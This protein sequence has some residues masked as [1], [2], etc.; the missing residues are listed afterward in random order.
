[1]KN[2]ILLSFDVEHWYLGFK[3][4]GV[5]GWEKDS[6]RDYN[7][8]EIILT[9]LE[10]YNSLAT[11]FVTGKYAE[12]Y[13][14]IVKKIYDKGHEISCHGYSHDYIYKQKPDIFKIETIQA[15]QILEDITGSGVTGYRAASWSITA[16]SLWAL[17]IIKDSGFLYDSSIYPTKNSKYG[18]YRAI[19]EPYKIIFDGGEEL[20]EIPP[21]VLKIGQIK[22]PVCGGIYLRLFPF[23]LNKLSIDIE[24]K[25][26]WPGRVMLHPHEL[27]E[28]PPRLKIN[29]EGWLVKYFRINTVGDTLDK[30]LLNFE[31]VLFEDYYNSLDSKSVESLK[32]D[33]LFK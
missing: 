15:K 4:R 8:I 11:F 3:S 7:N 25:S 33:N 23:W 17:D 18:I 16:D 10:K 31:T 32:I 2:K 1:M 28:H 21:Q 22:L 30:L 14:D 26:G 29:F 6:W 5:V 19:T 24:N 9:K 20:V 13:P 12:D 27:D